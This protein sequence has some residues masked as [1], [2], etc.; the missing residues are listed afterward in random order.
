MATARDVLGGASFPD[1]C[2]AARAVPRVVATLPVTVRPRETVSPHLRLSP[3]SV[4]G[5][6]ATP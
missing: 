1:V 2:V 5:R 4:V 6:M 3:L